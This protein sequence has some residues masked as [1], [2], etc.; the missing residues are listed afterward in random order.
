[1]PFCYN[2]LCLEQND[3]NKSIEMKEDPCHHTR[4]A[5]L[6]DL[7]IDNP[8]SKKNKYTSNYFLLYQNIMNKETLFFVQIKD[9]KKSIFS[10]SI[11]FGVFLLPPSP[12]LSFF[13]DVVLPL[14]N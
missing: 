9:L 6:I 2:N 10:T 8:L 12:S 11:P 1:M 14:V 13:N 4:K 5:F 7:L 3:I